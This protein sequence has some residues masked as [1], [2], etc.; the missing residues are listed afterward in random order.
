MTNLPAGALSSHTREEIAK[1]E[2]GE[3]AVSRPVAI[4]L[5]LAL[6]GVTGSILLF[7]LVLA[8]SG[9]EAARRPWTRLRQ[10][11]SEVVVGWTS[12]S[13]HSSWRA[14]VNANRAALGG[15]HEFEEGLEDESRLGTLLRP[16]AQALLTGALG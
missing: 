4:F 9:D 6:L 16:G 11:P 7:E 10:L 15:L 1:R 13:S 14:L 12:G 5:L 8:A 3:T 2:I